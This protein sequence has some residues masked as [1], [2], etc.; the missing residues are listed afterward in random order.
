[1]KGAFAS[2]IIFAKMFKNVLKREKNAKIKI[3]AHWPYNTCNLSAKKQKRQKFSEITS[4]F[5]PKMHFKVWWIYNMVNVLRYMARLFFFST[6]WTRGSMFQ[7]KADLPCIKW[8]WP[9]FIY[10]PSKY[11]VLSV[12]ISKKPMLCPMIYVG[13]IGFSRC[14][15]LHNYRLIMLVMSIWISQIGQETWRQ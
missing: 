10:D 7:K 3:L 2:I 1:M 4:H 6:Y 11:T 12:I 14:H 15:R 13:Y 8:Q 9:C 5:Y